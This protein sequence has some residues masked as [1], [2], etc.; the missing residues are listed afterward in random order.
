MLKTIIR[1]DSDIATRLS[2]IR[3]VKV[4]KIRIRRDYKATFNLFLRDCQRLKVL[5]TMDAV[6]DRCN[7]SEIYC[8]EPL[9]GD[10]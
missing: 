2:K 6:V 7:S 3:N 5:I 1:T 8:N 4:Y 9:I 10:E